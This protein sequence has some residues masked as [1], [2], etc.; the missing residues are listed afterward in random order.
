MLEF[1]ALTAGTYRFGIK[2]RSGASAYSLD[3]K[4][5]SDRFLRAFALESE[6]RM[7]VVTEEEA[8]QTA[9]DFDLAVAMPRTYAGY[10]GAMRAVNPRLTVLVYLNASFS[11]A[12]RAPP[13]R[14]PGT[15]GTRTGRRSARSPT[16]TT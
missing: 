6:N 16:A 7:H 12:G 1:T 10:L 3:V 11:Q 5:K 14:S 9:R 13:T 4:P 8:L 15:R 2:A